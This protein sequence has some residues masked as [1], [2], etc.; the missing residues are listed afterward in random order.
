MR[1][2]V[3]ILTLIT[4]IL[5]AVI[6][7]L[8]V[9]ASTQADVANR[10][11]QRLALEASALTVSHT[12]AERYQTELITSVL[13]ATQ[14]FLALSISSL[15][16][17]GKDDAAAASQVSVLASAAKARA[18]RASELSDVYQDPRYAPA[19][20]DTFPDLAA[21]LD[22][23][24]AEIAAIVT[25]Q[26]AAADTYNSWDSKSSSYV[27]VLSVLAITFFLLGLAQVSKRMRPFLAGSA[28][29]LMIAAVGWTVSIA[30]G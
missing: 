20:A 24:N 8:E 13:D 15:D 5:A 17:I 11:S 22:D 14:E 27:A 30:S 9:E 25:R 3:V 2:V 7:G 1:R 16:L 10:D 21:Y 6:A 29:L 12:V 4:T 18:A 23:R 26:N 19:T 28:G